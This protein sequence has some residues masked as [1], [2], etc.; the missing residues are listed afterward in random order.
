MNMIL[1]KRLADRYVARNGRVVI[2]RRKG[3]TLVEVIVVLV[4]LAILAAIA[5]PA[6][7]GYIDKAEDKKY[8]ADARNRTVAY[9]AVLDEAYADGEFDKLTDAQKT[10]WVTS[11]SATTADNLKIFDVG[12]TT[13]T[14]GTGFSDF[15]RRSAKLTGEPF[16]ANDVLA[17][18]QPMW[19]IFFFAPKGSTY[20][21][22]DAPAFVYKYYPEGFG[23]KP[24][25]LVYYGLKG[26][27][28]GS[29]G[30]SVSEKDAIYDPGAGYTV[31]HV[32]Q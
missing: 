7:T 10:A 24:Y 8:I 26:L 3:F 2:H 17:Y 22:F 11:G 21:V 15:F 30:G 16:P 9:R 12:S 6:L 19:I 4:I 32:K 28:Q 1:K 20:T 29:S 14:L 31:F 13:V 23:K 18:S 25:T 27:K 5:I